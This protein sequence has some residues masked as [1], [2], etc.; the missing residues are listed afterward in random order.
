MVYKSVSSKLVYFPEVSLYRESTVR[1]K[2]FGLAFD[3]TPQELASRDLLCTKGRLRLSLWHLLSKLLLSSAADDP[4]K[5][6]KASAHFFT[7][8]VDARCRY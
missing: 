2:N 6:Q 7:A 3:S 8:A 5:T 4:N 1:Y